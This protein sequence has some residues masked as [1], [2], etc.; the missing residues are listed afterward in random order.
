VERKP[1]KR[2]RRARV[3]TCFA[4]GE[5]ADALG[6]LRDRLAGV[7]EGADGADE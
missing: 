5:R 2:G 4:P 3:A 6:E 1:E 7:L